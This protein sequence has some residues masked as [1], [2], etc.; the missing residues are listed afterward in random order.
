MENGISESLRRNIPRIL[1]IWEEQAYQNILSSAG[2]TSLVLKNAI[3]SF[4]EY[5]ADE[6]STTVEKTEVRAAQDKLNIVNFA[7]VHGGGR[8]IEP[9]H[10]T[11][12]EVIL[13]FQILQRVILE[14]LEEH[15]SIPTSDRKTIISVINQALTAA[16]TQFAEIQ[17][18]TQEQFALTLVHDLRSPIHAATMGVYIIK[19]DTTASMESL[20]VADKIGKN[21]GTP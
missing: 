3:H 11:L 17:R 13:E 8:A 19:Q 14:I 4:L 1:A 5:L 18:Q 20:H 21:L 16:A 6:L 7:K 2:V 9:L 12:A 15:S 10:Y